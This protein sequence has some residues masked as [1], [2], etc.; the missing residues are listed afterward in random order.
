MSEIIYAIIRDDETSKLKKVVESTYITRPI[1][2][3]ELCQFHDYAIDLYDAYCSTLSSVNV[4]KNGFVPQET[5]RR[6]AVMFEEAISRLTKKYKDKL[7]AHSH[8]YGGWKSFVWRFNDDI[9]FIIRTNFGYGSNS[10][11]EQSV[12]YKGLKLAPYSKLVKYRYANFTSITSHTYSYQFIYSEWDKLMSDALYFYNA[13]VEHKDNHIFHWLTQHLDKMVYELER[14]INASYCYFDNIIIENNKGDISYRTSS[15]RVEGDDFWIA[16]S[17]KI[18]EALLFI[19]NISELPIQVDPE[20]Y[21]NH[22]RQI[23]ETFFPLLEDKIELLKND[24]KKLQ[25]NIDA[26]EN[27]TPYALYIKL[28]DKYYYEKRWHLSENN[29]S[30]I[31]FLMT[32]L[33]RKSDIN[34]TKIREI[35]KTLDKQIQIL[36]EFKNK[37]NKTNSVIYKLSEDRD[38]IVEF[39][40]S[41]EETEE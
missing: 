41:K 7:I 23:N 10:Y 19:D 26:I 31:R 28:Y 1:S 4:N 40:N 32:I 38:K 12:Y 14:Y 27:E 11:F 29:Y 37:L 34:N 39:F 30:M 3:A 18:S 22:I 9:K 15:E 24:A 5:F 20:K 17:N 6:K 8:R 2:D 16:K 35:L 21:V 25:D 36:D 13:I 33:R